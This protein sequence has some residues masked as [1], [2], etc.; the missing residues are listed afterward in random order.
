MELIAGLAWLEVWCCST[1]EFLILFYLLVFVFFFFF[2]GGGGFLP[3]QSDCT[4]RYLEGRPSLIVLWGLRACG[5][6]ARPQEASD[7]P[8]LRFDR[9]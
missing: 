5:H 9:S 7:R 1:S 3:S 2:F 8:L 4:T 6:W